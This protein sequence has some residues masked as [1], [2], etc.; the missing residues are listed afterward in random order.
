M[1]S[2]SRV[3]QI[4]ANYKLS[5]P[6][7]FALFVVKN[8]TKLMQYHGFVDGAEII[9]R[10]SP[11]NGTPCYELYGLKG[12]MLQENLIEASSIEFVGHVKW[13]KQ[14][15]QADKTTGD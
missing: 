11:V 9:S 8:A 1:I 2:E 15:E 12:P 7:S 5:M 13:R 4:N 6:D 10:R 3:E 14:T